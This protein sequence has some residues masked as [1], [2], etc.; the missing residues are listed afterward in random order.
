MRFTLPALCVSEELSA[1]LLAAI[2]VLQNRVEFPQEFIVWELFLHRLRL[3]CLQ[4]VNCCSEKKKKKI[5]LIT[6][7][8]KDQNNVERVPDKRFTLIS[9][10]FYFPL[11]V[12]VSLSLCWPSNQRTLSEPS[13]GEASPTTRPGCICTCHVIR[14][15]GC[16]GIKKRLSLCRAPTRNQGEARRGE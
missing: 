10:L 4:L 8:L 9:H 12:Q 6:L 5:P 16:H 14:N 7:Q 3:Q 11:P 1:A 15:T 2:N 13:A